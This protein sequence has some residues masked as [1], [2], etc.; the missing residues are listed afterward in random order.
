MALFA[1]TRCV[2]QSRT[3]ERGYVP[4]ETQWGE[5][6]EDERPSHVPRA[7]RPTDRTLRLRIRRSLRTAL[8]LV[9]S[10]SR[11]SGAPGSTGNLGQWTAF[12]RAC[13][14]DQERPPGYRP[15]QRAHRAVPIAVI[16]LRKHP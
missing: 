13:L 5:A 11:P 7:R 14:D 12:S 10:H 16:M 3:D 15:S 4:R 1:H 2:G 9:G 6:V 8:A